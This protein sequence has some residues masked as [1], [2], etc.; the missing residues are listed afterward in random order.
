M[1]CPGPAGAKAPRSQARTVRGLTREAGAE[2]GGRG[3][4]DLEVEGPWPG[5]QL[6][7]AQWLQVTG[8]REL[9]QGQG[10]SA[11]ELS[12]GPAGGGLLMRTNRTKSQRLPL[13][14]GDLGHLP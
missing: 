10:E 2:A 3:P 7:Q 4:A 13:P 1:R 12:A 14:M 9:G 11:A 6:F 5:G 8:A